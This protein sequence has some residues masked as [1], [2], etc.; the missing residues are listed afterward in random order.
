MWVWRVRGVL[1][2]TEVLGEEK[3]HQRNL[4]KELV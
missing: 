2:A 4:K 1:S 3:R